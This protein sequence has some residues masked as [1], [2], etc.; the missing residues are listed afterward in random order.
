[1]LAN[2]RK[3]TP[4]PDLADN[5]LDL[6][7]VISVVEKDSSPLAFIR[8]KKGE[9]QLE[10]HRRLLFCF[11]ANLIMHGVNNHRKASPIYAV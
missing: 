9:K 11:F 10:G 6:V 3:D 7:P 4:E 1:M 2:S 5:F 8:T